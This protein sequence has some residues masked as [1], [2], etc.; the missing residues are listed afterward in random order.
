M[1]G[2]AASFIGELR[3][4]CLGLAAFPER[5]PLVLRHAAKRIRRRVHG[6]TL[7]FQ[8]AEADRIGVIPILDRA[9]DYEAILF[10]R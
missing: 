6:N 10:P 4:D 8:R 5:F 7:I 1:I 9:Q 3:D 2:N